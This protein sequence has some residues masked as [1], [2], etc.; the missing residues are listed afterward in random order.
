MPKIERLLSEFQMT[1]FEQLIHEQ[2]IGTATRADVMNGLQKMVPLQVTQIPVELVPE[3][4]RE[5]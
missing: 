5:I 1:S 2:Q 4:S 3:P